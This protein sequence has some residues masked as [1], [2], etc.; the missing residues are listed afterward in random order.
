MLLR[1]KV[2]CIITPALGFAI[3]EKTDGFELESAR[4]YTRGAT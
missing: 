4:V 1:S 2:R 3:L